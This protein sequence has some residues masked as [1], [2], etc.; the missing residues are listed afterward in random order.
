MRRCRYVFIAA[1][2]VFLLPCFLS[3]AAP[4][5]RLCGIS[6]GSTVSEMTSNV[7]TEYSVNITGE[8]TKEQFATRPTRVLINGYPGSANTYPEDLFIS[9]ANAYKRLYPDCFNLIFVWWTI[10][11]DSGYHTRVFAKDYVA[12]M[13]T[14]LLDDKLRDNQEAWKNLK[15]I[16]YDIGAHIAGFVGK[17]VR[18]GTVG[19]IIGL[20]PQG[21]Y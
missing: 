13:I 17:N 5:W 3:E 21:V 18:R 7:T 15:I 2:Q 20:D 14:D 9:V 16:G 1:V 19:T 8:Y 6:I 4:K 11:A 12:P 10:D